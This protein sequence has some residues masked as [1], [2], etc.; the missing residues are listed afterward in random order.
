MPINNIMNIYI[1][2]Y[3]YSGDIIYENK[4]TTVTYIKIDVFQQNKEWKKTC[5]E[6]YVS[7][8]FS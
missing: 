2:I 5:P 3:S 4:W 8:D 1:Y 6:E 7:Y